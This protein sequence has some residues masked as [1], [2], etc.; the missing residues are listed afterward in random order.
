MVFLIAGKKKKN[1]ENAKGPSRLSHG[2]LK[3]KDK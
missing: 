2:A 3:N 1:S